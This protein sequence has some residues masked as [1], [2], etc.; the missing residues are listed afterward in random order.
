VAI[1]GNCYKILFNQ[2]LVT[3]YQSFIKQMNQIL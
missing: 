1:D 2:K 3:K